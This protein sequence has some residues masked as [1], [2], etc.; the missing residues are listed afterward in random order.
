ML[1]LCHLM[2]HI[3]VIFTFFSFNIG[4]VLVI[5]IGPN[6]LVNKILHGCHDFPYFHFPLLEVET[7]ETN[8]LALLFL[9]FGLQLADITIT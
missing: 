1:V 2:L 6:W 7:V 4:S 5:G 9:I 8:T 3:Q